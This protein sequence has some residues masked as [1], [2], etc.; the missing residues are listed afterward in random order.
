IG[1]KPC[2][3]YSFYDISK[4]DQL[5]SELRS[6]N[7]ELQSFTYTVSHDLK[8][9]LV[10]ISGFL[11]YLEEDV[12]KGDEARVSKDILRITQA[13]AKMQRLISELMEVSRIGRIVSPPEDIPFSEIV[14]DA[15]K[16]VEGRMKESQVKVEVDADLPS[17]RGDR[18]RLV[19]VVQNL[20][21]NA[22]KF[23][24]AQS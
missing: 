2:Q 3:L 9:P 20:V 22:A 21:D 6:K 12:K 18:V 23:M 1:D 8:A 14:Q 11:G 5:M 17:V 13:V 19:E 16:A 24:G 7:D 10:T 4:I 15:L